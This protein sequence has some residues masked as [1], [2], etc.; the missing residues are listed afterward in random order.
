MLPFE[1][2]YLLVIP[3]FV[4]SL[5]LPRALIPVF[6]RHGITGVDVHKPD[7]PVRAEMGGAVIL[8]SLAIV[9]IL[10]LFFSGVSGQVLWALVSLLL[11]G[12]VGIID[13]LY[14]FRQRYKPLLTFLASMPFALSLNQSQ[15]SIP[16]I[17]SLD[18]G[19]FYKFLLVPLAISTASNLTNMLAGFNGL[20]LGTA[21]ISLGALLVASLY[22]A[23]SS[24]VLLTA[25][26]LSSIV[27]V[28]RYNWC[29][30]RIFPGDSGTLLVGASIAT[31]SILLRL[32]FFGILLLVPAAIDFAL[33]FQSRNPFT[34]RRLYGDTLV[35]KAGEL[36]APAYP[37]LA[38]MFLRAE[39][40][41]EEE[42]VTNLLLIQLVY[43]MVAFGVLL[44]AG[45]G[46]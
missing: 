9:T 17:G 25:L 46:G 30:A 23:Q 12:G 31:I 5:V 14:A 39:R 43:G 40:M 22:V 16:G 37:A 8:A 42:L 41:T 7:R 34:Q 2:S 15:I 4:S 26:L 24:A 3:A 33:K 38:H 27:P 6:I 28:L 19:V 36:A 44:L 32:E 11:V 29:P 21:S 20:E 10:L 35:T 13:D 18:A 1:T 45:R